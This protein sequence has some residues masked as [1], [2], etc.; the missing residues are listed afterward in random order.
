MAEE[1]A[2]FLKCS[3]CKLEGL[4]LIH[5]DSNKAGHGETEL[6]S[7]YWGGRESLGLPSGPHSLLG[8]PQVSEKLYLLKA[9]TNKQGGQPRRRDTGGSPLVSTPMHADPTMRMWPFL[10]ASYRLHRPGPTHL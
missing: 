7:L 10:Q 1:T 3:P 5:P 4:G 8:K 6:P 2:R 9:K